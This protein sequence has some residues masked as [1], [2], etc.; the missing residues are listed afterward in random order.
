MLERPSLADDDRFATNES[1]CEHEAAL[2]TQIESALGGTDAA[3]WIDRLAAAGI[4]A[5]P[6]QDV[7]EV[8]NHPQVVA[9]AMV[10]E[11]AGGFAGLAVAGNPVKLSTD[12]GPAGPPR[13]P[14]LDEHADALRR[15]S[16]DA[17]QALRRQPVGQVTVARAS[18]SDKPVI[19]RLLE[20][21]SHDFSAIDGRALGPH[22]EYGYP[23]LDHYWLDGE[24]RH[25]FLVTVDEE[26]AGCALV[27]AGHPHELAEFFVVRKFRRRGVGTA[28]ARQLFGRFPGPWI[29]RE[30]AGNDDATAFWRR[31]IPY[32]FDERVHDGGVEQSF[33]VPDEST[34]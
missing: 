3:T 1:R 28:A 23:Y 25:P 9:R 33:V 8:M 10:Q 7:A 34:R 12:P 15:W 17:P 5:G 13:A 26:I 24:D 6:V 11:L 21:N 29:V 20:L 22:G 31:A 27:R 2:R 30:M 14:I 19:R 18:E 16:A 32:P 4:P